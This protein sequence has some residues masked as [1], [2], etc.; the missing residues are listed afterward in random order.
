[1]AVV[2]LVDHKSVGSSF[3]E[4]KIFLEICFIPCCTFGALL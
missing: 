2:I 3:L 4:R 1:M